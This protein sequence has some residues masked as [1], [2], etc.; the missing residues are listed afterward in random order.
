M[1]ESCGNR[2]NREDAK[3]DQP[4]L[5]P[6]RGPSEVLALQSSPIMS[7]HPPPSIGCRAMAM[8]R[9]SVRRDTSDERLASTQ[10]PNLSAEG[11]PQ[12]VGCFE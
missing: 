5:A 11:R 9:P 12:G 6:S 7:T 2:D 4:T 3:R 1:R 10:W 8:A